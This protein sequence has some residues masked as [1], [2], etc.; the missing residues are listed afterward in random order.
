MHNTDNTW[1]L[2]TNPARTDAPRK[3]GLRL[4][5]CDTLH[6]M[7]RHHEAVAEYGDE[8]EELV[9]GGKAPDSQG[10]SMFKGRDPFQ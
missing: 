4:L 3:E 1:N 7:G 5:L 10:S 8:K 6:E 2:C 9:G